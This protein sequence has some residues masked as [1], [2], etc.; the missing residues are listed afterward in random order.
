MLKQTS[1]LLAS[2]LLLAAFSAEAYTVILK[3]NGKV[4]NG[5]LVSEE[6]TTIVFRDAEGVLYSLKEK[7]PGTGENERGK[8]ATT[9]TTPSCACA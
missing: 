2:I 1:V 5:T 7:C 9:R 6:E 3:K 8:R 4:L